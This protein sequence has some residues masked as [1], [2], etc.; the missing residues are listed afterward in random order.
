MNN[1]VLFCFYCSSK[2]IDSPNK[3]YRTDDGTKE[4]KDSEP[5]HI[6]ALV[7]K[8]NLRHTKNKGSE[9]FSVCKYVSN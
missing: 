8:L 3:S 7:L 2:C 6:D 5:G 9:E 1:I 4:L